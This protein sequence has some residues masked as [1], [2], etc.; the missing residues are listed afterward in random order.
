MK[1]KV[2]DSPCDKSFEQGILE[3]GQ[4]IEDLLLLEIASITQ[5]L[6]LFVFVFAPHSLL[7]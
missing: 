3:T 1:Y 7:N 5:D 2:D 4:V 6:S